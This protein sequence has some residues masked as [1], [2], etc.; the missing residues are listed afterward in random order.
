MSTTVSAPPP[1]GGRFYVYWREGSSRTLF[2][3]RA[4]V[5]APSAALARQRFR[6]HRVASPRVLGVKERTATGGCGAAGRWVG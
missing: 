2:A 6:P 1:V 4:A 5:E 3:F